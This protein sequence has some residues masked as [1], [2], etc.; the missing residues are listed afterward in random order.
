MTPA[1]LSSAC[2]GVDAM[3]AG[4]HASWTALTNAGVKVIVLGDTPHRHER[5]R[6]R[7]G[8]HRPP[9]PVYHDRAKGVAGSSLSTQRTRSPV[10]EVKLV[11][12]TDR[13]PD[14]EMRTGHR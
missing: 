1:G 12:L 2:R 7:L 11:D 4:M 6:V 8:E 5:V 14:T 13:S 10:P 9:D 3:V